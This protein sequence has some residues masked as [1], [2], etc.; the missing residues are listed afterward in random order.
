MSCQMAL[1]P[2]DIEALERLLALKFQEHLTPV[3]ERIDGLER[4][5]NGRFD[6]VFKQLE[7]L[8]Q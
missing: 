7:T 2:E 5:M 6:D 4:T 3:N 8:Q 1:T